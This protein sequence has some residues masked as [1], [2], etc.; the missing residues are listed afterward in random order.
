MPKHQI[1]RKFEFDAG[2]R[3]L[4]HEGKCRHLH[5]HRY[6]LEVSVETDGLDKLGRVIDFGSMKSVLGNWIDENWDHNMILNSQDPLVS[7]SHLVGRLPYI[8][9][10]YAANPTVENLIL[11]FAQKAKELLAGSGLVLAKIRMYETPNCWAEWHN[12]SN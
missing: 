3:V 2:H 8:M 1:T 9:P 11:V 4:G 7:S 6:T 5:G 12:Q 10:D